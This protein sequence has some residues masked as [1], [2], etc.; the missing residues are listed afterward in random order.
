MDLDKKQKEL[1]KGIE[2]GTKEAVAGWESMGMSHQ[3]AKL[4]EKVETVNLMLVPAMTST[5]LV[6]GEVVQM[7]SGKGPDSDALK[8][9][10]SNI[11]QSV[12]QLSA[13]FEIPLSEV[14]EKA[15]GEKK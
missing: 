11:V 14:V 8:E 13:L 6:A 4:S 5:G 10:L 7:Y 9:H 3:F 15:F 1:F 12:S 2:E